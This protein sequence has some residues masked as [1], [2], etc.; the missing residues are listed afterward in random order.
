MNAR[1]VL[2]SVADATGATAL[3][4]AIVNANDGAIER[5][6]AEARKHGISEAKIAKA[7]RA[8]KK[9]ERIHSLVALLF[10][11]LGNPALVRLVAGKGKK[12]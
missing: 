5:L 6:A 12:K 8:Q 7:R 10:P 2:R 11:F 3:A 1:D 4:Q 9:F